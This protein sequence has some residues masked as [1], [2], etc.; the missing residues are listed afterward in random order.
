ML[1]KSGGDILQTSFPGFSPKKLGGGSS[2]VEGVF[3]GNFRVALGIRG[4]KVL[5]YNVNFGQGRV[6]YHSQ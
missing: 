2:Q 3:P 1:L 6:N 4:F 5:R